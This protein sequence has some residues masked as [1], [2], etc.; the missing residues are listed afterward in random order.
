[1]NTLLIHI[2]SPKTGTTALQNFLY[3]N[4][5][6]LE[7]HNWRYP[8]TKTELFEISS[9]KAKKQING[10][11]FFKELTEENGRTAW[12]RHTVDVDS[13]RWNQ[14]WCR[15]LEHLKEKNVIISSEVLFRD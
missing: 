3:D 14:V 7:D 9:L 13:E 5:D 10:A 2:G 8:D 1:M 11:I 6:K 15:I 12:E 4:A